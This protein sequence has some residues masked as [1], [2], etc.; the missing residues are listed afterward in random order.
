MARF[1]Q[2]FTHN[3]QPPMSSMSTLHRD[4][5]SSWLIPYQTTPIHQRCACL[6]LPPSSWQSLF[7]QSEQRTGS[8]FTVASAQ[9]GGNDPLEE[10]RLKAW[11]MHELNQ[12]FACKEVDSHMFFFAWVLAQWRVIIIFDRINSWAT[13]PTKIPPLGVQL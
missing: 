9:V 1:G 13:V 10:C 12:R 5:C 7:N 6:Q 4:V 3:S 2:R 8:D 11:N